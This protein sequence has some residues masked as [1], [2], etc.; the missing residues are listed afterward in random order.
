[1]GKNQGFKPLF[2][3]IITLLCLC[4]IIGTA[5]AGGSKG[6]YRINISVS[7]SSVYPNT[8][9]VAEHAGADYIYLGNMEIDGYFWFALSSVGGVTATGT[10]GISVYCQDVMENTAAAWAAAGVSYVMT[11]V[12]AYS[13]ATK[14]KVYC[15]P[16]GG[17]YYRIGFHTGNSCAPTG[18]LS[19]RK[20]WG[21]HESYNK[22]KVAGFVGG[23]IAYRH[24]C[25]WYGISGYP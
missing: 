22:D 3:I 1:M 12:D 7:G 17:E 6:T 8:F 25:L 11:N 23:D 20:I 14:V 21:G 18:I 24:L 4:F 13:G 5:I 10:T 9:T 19:I 16:T 15:S 2:L